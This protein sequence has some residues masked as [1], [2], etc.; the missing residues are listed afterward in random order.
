MYI[1]DC[2]VAKAEALDTASA[3]LSQAWALGR[4]SFAA[5]RMAGAGRARG[6]SGAAKKYSASRGIRGRMP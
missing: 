1:R 4:N 3:T 2:G 6:V 5:L